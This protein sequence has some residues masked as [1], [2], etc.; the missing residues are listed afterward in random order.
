MGRDWIPPDDQG[1]LTLL[2]NLPE[3][4]SLDATS[5]VV[6]HIASKVAAMKGIEFVNPYIHEGLGSPRT[7][8]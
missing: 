5:R 8:T 2:L 3:G 1:E 6:T 4:T 7:S